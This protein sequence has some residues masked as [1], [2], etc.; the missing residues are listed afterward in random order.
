MDV[1]GKI[2]NVVIDLPHREG[3][4]MRFHKN[5]GVI[6]FPAFSRS[7]LETYMHVINDNL[8]VLDRNGESLI[9]HYDNIDEVLAQ[10][11]EGLEDVNQWKS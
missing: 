5:M 6:R 3:Y 4:N 9:I 10:Y 1:V 7:E 11:D 8:R 2:P